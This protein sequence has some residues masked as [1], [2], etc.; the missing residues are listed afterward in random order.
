MKT[1]SLSLLLLSVAL[2]SSSCKDEFGE[3]L[4]P[5]GTKGRT[6]EVSFLEKA[7]SLDS[8]AQVRRMG[9]D[10]LRSDPPPRDKDQW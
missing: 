10:S 9:P 5:V 3:Q 8:N 2:F 4:A 1:K 7:V 6:S